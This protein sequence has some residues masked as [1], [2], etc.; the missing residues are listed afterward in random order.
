MVKL[1]KIYYISE[2]HNTYSAPY[3]SNM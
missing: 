3:H 2:F 1:S